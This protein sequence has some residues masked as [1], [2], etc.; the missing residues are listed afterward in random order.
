MGGGSAL[1][2]SKPTNLGFDDV[3]R[4]SLKA[5]AGAV[6]RGREREASMPCTRT[7]RNMVMER[8]EKNFLKFVLCVNM[9]QQ[10]VQ[11]AITTL[12]E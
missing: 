7:R 2:I 10:P 6:V 9:T 11:S 4:T 8:K 5:C 3:E 12:F 1:L